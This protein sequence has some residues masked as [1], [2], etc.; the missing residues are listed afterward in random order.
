MQYELKGNYY[1]MFRQKLSQVA[2]DP[3]AALESYIREDGYQEVL[4]WKL[5]VERGW[6]AGRNKSIAIPPNIY[7]SAGD[8]EDFAT[9]SRDLRLRLSML[10]LPEL[11][12]QAMT[13]AGDLRTK[14]S[15]NA[16]MEPA[17]LG[18]VLLALKERLRGIEN[19]VHGQQGR[20]DP[21]CP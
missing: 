19:R 13:M 2:P 5:A 15:R 17:E 11:V 9:P 7:D 6:A 4:D 12:G 3:V 8:W 20:K 14:R 1:T 16:P 10:H 21:P 18:R